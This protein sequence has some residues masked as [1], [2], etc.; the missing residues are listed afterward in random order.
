MFVRFVVTLLVLACAF[1]KITNL[2]DAAKKDIVSALPGGEAIKQSF[3]FSGYLAING[4]EGASKM[5]HY[6]MVEASDADGQDAPVAFWTNGG[7][8]CSGL[9]GAFTEQGPFLTKSADGTLTENP[10]A[11]NKNVNMVF[12]EQ[13][14]GVGFSYS[15]AKDTKGDY[16]ADD[17]SA[18]NDNYNLIQAFFA[19]F[20]SL[21]KNKLYLTSES[22]GGH[23]LPT[24]SK[25]IV[26]KNT[27]GVEPH[28]NFKGFAVGNPA[29]TKYSMTPAMIDTYQGHQLLDKPTYD[30]WASKCK[31]PKHEIANAEQ[32][33]QIFLEIFGKMNDM[34]AYALDYPV[35]VS[36]TKLTARGQT[37]ALMRHALGHYKEETKAALGLADDYQPCEDDYLSTYLNR[38][39][40]KE[41]LHVKSDI[42]WSDCSRS[43]NY[44]Q[45]DV[46][47]DM[48][49]NYRYLLEGND[50]YD[51]DILVYSGD[52][53][54]VCATVGT[55]DWIYDLGYERAKGKEWRP[56]KDEEGQLGGFLTKFKNAR[57]AFAT[58]HGAGHEVPT[59]KP[60]AALQMFTNYLSGD[61]TSSSE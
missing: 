54:S 51:L 53:D 40:V 48:T 1:A 46:Y 30:T 13:P 8:G 59:Y 43:I 20:P 29:T 28:L 7:P 21:S 16:T 27:E 26:D 38:A 9:L 6:F 55:Q 36:D 37:G 23:Y 17:D 58:V 45:K 19:K 33:E 3:G 2:S 31:D 32:C 57:L 34:N 50:K 22:Y 14:C 18:A 10:Y 42:T 11:W 49:D 35:C 44:A 41:A 4:T 15:T 61:L 39:D 24:L 52:D 56:W 47:K 12:I 60:K 5:M 25:V